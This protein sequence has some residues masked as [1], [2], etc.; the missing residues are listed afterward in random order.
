MLL[1]V[2]KNTVLR[3]ER[4]RHNASNASVSCFM[5]VCWRSGRPLNGLLT[6]LF[7][8]SSSSSSWARTRY[9]SI[10][11]RLWPWVHL[12]LILSICCGT[13]S[14]FHVVLVCTTSGRSTQS[15][16][17]AVFNWP[18]FIFLFTI[19]ILMSLVIVVALQW[20]FQCFRNIV[21]FC[22]TALSL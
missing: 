3:F 8:F 9:P 12:L 14:Y 18:S 17:L 5:T 16:C 1:S 22:D 11:H 6:V 4:V 15:G 19:L 10:Y 20:G 7:S 2:L 13:V 21:F